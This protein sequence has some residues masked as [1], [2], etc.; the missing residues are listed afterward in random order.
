MLE[1]WQQSGISEEERLETL[2][3]PQSQAIIERLSIGALS[4]TSLGGNAVDLIVRWFPGHFTAKWH[5]AHF[6]ISAFLIF[7]IHNFDSALLSQPPF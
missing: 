6:T 3:V 1:N 2:L 5:L 7:H 4:K